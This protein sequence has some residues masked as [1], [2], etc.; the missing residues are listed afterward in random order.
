MNG[1]PAS[2]MAQRYNVKPDPMEGVSGMHNYAGPDIPLPG[3]ASTMGSVSQRIA[4][5]T[6]SGAALSSQSRSSTLFDDQSSMAQMP[7]P[8][9]SS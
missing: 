9:G 6:P 7:R 5:R 8:E 4:W 2:S 3:K 1:H